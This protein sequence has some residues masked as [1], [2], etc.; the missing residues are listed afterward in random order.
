MK[1]KTF[2]RKGIV[3]YDFSEP[4]FRDEQLSSGGVGSNPSEKKSR[5][6]GT[7]PGARP[8]LQDRKVYWDSKKAY[9][10]HPYWTPN[11]KYGCK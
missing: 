4:N 2:R 5:P 11:L 9:R 1:D 7:T 3:K 8:Y 10:E 6:F